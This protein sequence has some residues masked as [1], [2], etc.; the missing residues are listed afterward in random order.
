MSPLKDLQAR[1][2]KVGRIRTG[3]S[4]VKNGRQRPEKLT[5]FLLTTESRHVADAIAAVYGGKV[6]PYNPMGGS[7]RGWQVLIGIDEIPVAVPP[8][9]TVV[10]QWWEMWT[11]G[12]LQR[13]CDGETASVWGDGNGEQRVPCKCP[14]DLMD[15]AAAAAQRTPTACKPSTRVSLI[16]PDVPGTGT[17]LV[18]SHGLYAA[19]EM[20]GVAE[21]MARASAAGVMLPALL[22]LEQRDGV[23]RPGETTNKFAVPVLQLT[24]SIRELAAMAEAGPSASTLPPAPARPLAITTGSSDSADVSEPPA[25]TP[26]AAA[27]SHAGDRG[28]GPPPPGPET[29]AQPGMSA[30]TIADRARGS[31]AKAI[32]DALVKSATD[33][34]LGDDYVDD[35][36]GTMSPLS[37]VL[38]ERLDAIKAAS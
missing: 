6:D 27:T 22:R 30:Q 9:E 37:E 16:L 33:L 7:Q 21:L 3:I 25:E 20:G 19:Q 29:P 23:R 12:G 11:G 4:V 14:P 38:A 5:R 35:G 18:E 34:G 8:G 2:A 24:N 1:A 32:V 15:R 36:S 31:R 17:F 13:R 26:V 28:D 10:S